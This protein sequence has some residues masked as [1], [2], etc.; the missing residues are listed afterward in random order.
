MY[1]MYQQ[2]NSKIYYTGDF[3]AWTDDEIHLLFIYDNHQ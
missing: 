3:K 2:A 1:E